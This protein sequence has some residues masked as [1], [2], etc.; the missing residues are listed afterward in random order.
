MKFLHARSRLLVSRPNLAFPLLRLQPILVIEALFS[1]LLSL[2]LQLLSLDPRV[3]ERVIS[4][5]RGFLL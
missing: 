2:L 1:L 3:N 5:T 4:L